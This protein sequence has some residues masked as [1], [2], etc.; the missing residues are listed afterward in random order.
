MGPKQSVM[1]ITLRG[2][3]MRAAAMMSPSG[4]TGS[5]G[6]D[7]RHH[8]HGLYLLNSQIRIG[9][10]NAASTMKPGRVR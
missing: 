1:K 8:R 5:T 10:H 4:I 9:V 3:L 2:G 7:V 6:P